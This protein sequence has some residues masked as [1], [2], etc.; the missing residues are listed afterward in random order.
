MSF[1]VAPKYPHRHSHSHL[2]N[3]RFNS[4]F[5]CNS[6]KAHLDLTEILVD[7]AKGKWRHLLLLDTISSFAVNRE[8]SRAECERRRF[9]QYTALSE[10]IAN[11]AGE[12]YLARCFRGQTDMPDSVKVVDLCAPW[13]NIDVLKAHFLEDTSSKSWEKRKQA[14]DQLL[15]TDLIKEKGFANTI[16]M[17]INNIYRVHFTPK[18]DKRG[19]LYD[20][21]ST[22]ERI[23]NSKCS[24]MLVYSRSKVS[25]GK[26]QAPG[27]DENGATSQPIGAAL[28]RIVKDDPYLLVLAAGSDS[29]HVTRMTNLAKV[30]KSVGV[31]RKIV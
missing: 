25:Q 5:E 2:H 24:E 18:L 10:S 14:A 3:V 7:G 23:V 11:A 22:D 4:V 13:N 30:V 28:Q 29:P 1:K 20:R 26:A 27:V 31:V 6:A 19:A 15:N 12:A 17:V 21:F 8:K 16:S 9:D